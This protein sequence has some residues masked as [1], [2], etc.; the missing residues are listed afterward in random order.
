MNDTLIQTLNKILQSLSS[1]S[2]KTDKLFKKDDFGDNYESVKTSII[3]GVSVKENPQIV[4]DELMSYYSEIVEK[5]K[6]GDYTKS[7]VKNQLAMKM[8]REL[9]LKKITPL[10]TDISKYIDMGWQ[11]LR[12]VSWW[13]TYSLLTLLTDHQEKNFIG[14]WPE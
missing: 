12:G 10:F 7:D 14:E 4:N 9:N 5:I 8:N 11:P 1:S 13:F 3:K 6:S 2:L